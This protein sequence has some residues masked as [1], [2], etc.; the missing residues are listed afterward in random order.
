MVTLDSFDLSLLAAIQQDGRLTNQD[1][2]ER[3]NLSASQ[4]SRRR[5]RLETAG[6]IRGYRAVLS[7]RALHL[8]IAAFMQVTLTAHTRENAESFK[9][10][11]R[12][13][14]EVLDAFTLTGEADYLLR[15]VTR[16]LDAL[17]RLVND[18]LLTHPAVARV[19]SR[20]VLDRLKEHGAL[21]LGHM[22]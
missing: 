21:P 2:A 13:R 14:E 12:E 18:V 6:V 17:S 11:V 5:L 7:A 10:L 3:V 15:V 19:Q 4:C 20:I 16:N 1:L 9:A 22:T 8:E